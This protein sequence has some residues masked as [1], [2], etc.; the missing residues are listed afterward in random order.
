MAA[1]ETA[2]TAA[3]AAVAPRK[4]GNGAQT[5]KAIAIGAAVIGYLGLSY[6]GTLCGAT[7][8]YLV[9]HKQAPRSLSTGRFW[10]L[11]ADTAEDPQDRKKLKVGLIVCGIAFFGLP[12]AIA[13]GFGTRRELHGSARW[14]KHS[15]VVKA[16]LLSNTAGIVVGKL[17]NRFLTLPGQ[18]SVTLSAPTRSGKGVGVVVPNLLSW[19]DSVVV[20]DIKGENFELTAGFR[21]KHGQAVYVWAPFARD[22]RSHRWNVLGAVREQNRFRVG[23]L[24]GIAQVLYPSSGGGVSG[25]DKFFNEQARNLF[26]GLGLYLLETPELPR[27]IGEMLRQSSGK[28]KPLK[29]HLVELIAQRRESDHP[30]SDV[31]VDALNRFLGTSENTLT[32]I[33]ATFNAPLTVWSEQLVDAATSTSDFSLGDLRRRRMSVYVVIPPNRLADAA[34]LLNLFFSQSVNLNTEVLPQHDPALKHQ[35]L[36]VLDE[37]TA[38]GR[39]GI[40]AKGIGYIAGYNLRVLTVIQA[41]SQLDDTYGKEASRT[42]STNHALQILYAPREQRDANEYSE[43]LGTLTEKG[44]STG[45][46]VNNGPRGGST[47]SRNVSDQRRALLLP[48]EFKEL[49]PDREVVLYENCRPILAEKIRYYADPLLAPRVLPPPEVPLIDLGL[50]QARVEG[51]MRF[52]KP[53]EVFTLDQLAGDFG[54]LPRLSEDPTRDEVSS[55]VDAF[56]ECGAIEFERTAVGAKGADQEDAGEGAHG[57]PTGSSLADADG[58]ID[59]ERLAALR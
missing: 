47:T 17:G 33:L 53:E 10:D 31:C 11:W 32:S 15:E 54:R 25:T 3:P 55:L 19:S 26:L 34:V 14:A 2:S 49:G 40:L 57:T 56:F 41:V 46:S 37:F 13:A 22:G 18:Q 50:H 20:V 21:A 1:P 7:A 44:T 59:D 16:G 12:C 45:R 30:L 48:Q 23:D 27:T 39:V 9:A 24:L 36:F 8:V 52:A 35:C 38:M 28:G 6:V 51:R 4:R 58:A 43:M 5:F 42:F 29:D